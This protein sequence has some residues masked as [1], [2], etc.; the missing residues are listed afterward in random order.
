M[1]NC[2]KL[3]RA[4]VW[5]DGDEWE[6]EWAAGSEAKAAAAEAKVDRVEV[7]IKV[8]K[9]QLQELLEKAGG[10]RGAC[11]AK[12]RQAEKVLAELMT[13]GRVCYGQQHEEM[14]GHWRPALCSIPESAAEES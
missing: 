3:Q 12:A 14:R 5:A 13:S 10:G 9:R 6:E 11:K 8:T 2:L 7:K 4:A 1:G